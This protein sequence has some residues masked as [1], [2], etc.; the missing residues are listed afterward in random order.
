MANDTIEEANDFGQLDR[1]HQNIQANLGD[2]KERCYIYDAEYH[3]FEQ[4]EYID[5]H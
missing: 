3:T 5:T 2:D 4:L 1:Q